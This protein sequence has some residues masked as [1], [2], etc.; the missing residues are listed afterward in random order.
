MRK[1]WYCSA[2]DGPYW[3]E[4]RAGGD[5]EGVV[6]EYPAFEVPSYGLPPV[7]DSSLFMETRFNHT[8]L[9]SS[10]FWLGSLICVCGVMLT[11]LWVPRPVS[12]T[13]ANGLSPVMG[14]STWVSKDDLIE[15]L[16]DEQFREAASHTHFIGEIIRKTGNS[17]SVDVARLAM[18]I[19]AE[20]IKANYDPLFVAAVIKAESTFDH[21]VV[22]HKGAHGLMQILP[23]T[24]QYISAKNGVKWNGRHGLKDPQYNVRLGIAYLKYLE[25]NFGGNRRL[26][27]IAYNWGPGNLS[28]ALKNGAPIP[29]GSTQFASKILDRHEKWRS[30][31]Q[32]RMASYR[33]MDI[34]TM[35]S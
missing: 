23:E 15:R 9:W 21:G 30:D 28:A 26:A 3:D 11:M 10:V 16:S 6:I 19:V 31:L 33:Y 35:L 22:S 2:T 34:E 8:R 24:G 5:A 20:S 32:A 1:A 12:V 4:Q 27:L 17:D 13:Q 7:R 29:R 14:V 18:T 25:E